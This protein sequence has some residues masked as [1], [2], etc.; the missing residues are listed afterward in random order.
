[1]GGWFAIETAAGTFAARITPR[2]LAELRFPG[3]R[4]VKFSPAAGAPPPV[5]ALFRATERAVKA[6]LA[7]TPHGEMPPLDWDGAT[8]FQCSVWRELLRIPAGR[9]RSYGEIATRLRKPGA[10]RAVGAACGANPVPLLVPCH[11]VLAGDGGLGGFSCGLEWKRRLLDAEGAA[12][13]RGGMTNDR[14]A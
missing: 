13:A 3:G 8:Q 6:A 7:G 12:A 10:A 4:D 11:R 2:G 14:R 9:T 1:V 5:R